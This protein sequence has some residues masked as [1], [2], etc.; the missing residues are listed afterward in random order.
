MSIIK[1]FGQIFSLID[2]NS[3]TTSPVGELSADGKSYV[4]DWTTHTHGNWTDCEFL[5]MYSVDDNLSPTTPSSSQYQAL[6]E[7]ISWTHAKAR[8][9]EIGPSKQSYIE[10]F[11][12]KFS[13]RFT[14]L[15]SGA[16][17]I[18]NSYWYPG[19]FSIC[20]VGNETKDNWT[21]WLSDL[22]FRNDFDISTLFVVPPIDNI[23][24]FFNTT[25]YVKNK[26]DS[27]SR[28]EIMRKVELVR[29]DYP[30][31]VLRMDGFDWINPNDRFDKIKTY[32]NI[33][34]YGR[35]G[36]NIDSVKDAIIKYVMANTSHTI[37]EWAEIFP[38]IFRSTEFIFAPTY[39]NQGV[40]DKEFERGVYS[41]ISSVNDT[42]TL[43]KRVAKGTNYNNT[44]IAANATIIPSLFRS[45]QVGV[46][47]GP[48]NRE[49]YET[50]RRVY[51]DLL[52]V[53]TTHID[54]MRMSL[55]TRNFV[56]AL[57]EMLEEA[58]KLTPST[59][60]PSGYNRVNRDG[61]WYLAKSD[62]DLLLL[63]VTKYSVMEAAESLELPR[64]E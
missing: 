45:V 1:G 13:G 47:P 55:E 10:L 50:L 44:H 20:P 7:V 32:W 39:F 29:G 49:G 37:D 2:N 4:R 63:V 38:D 17:V 16:A 30:Y 27:V 33:V 42:V 18:T 14:L 51:H 60:V 8:S 62:R 61:I 46:V 52:N 36:D 53:P 6:L 28:T 40:P 15:D 21:C 26:V 35:A 22:F 31:T 34:I 25:S 24:E 12:G 59:V 43:L 23:D 54:F 58:E 3:H 19:Y 9:G 41:A 11:E 48:E 5:S 57:T 64:D 56:I